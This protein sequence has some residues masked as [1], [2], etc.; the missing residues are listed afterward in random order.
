MNLVTNHK[1]CYLLFHVQ[2]PLHIAAKDGKVEI[3]RYLVQYGS[4]VDTKDIKRLS[5]V[6]LAKVNFQT[7]I[8]DFL[9]GKRGKAVFK[10]KHG[11]YILY[12]T[13]T[14]LF[15]FKKSVDDQCSSILGLP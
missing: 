7:E 15:C 10:E 1:K 14:T 5:P 2:T 6:E 13:K 8:V 9:K 3:A 12:H 4:D 11:M